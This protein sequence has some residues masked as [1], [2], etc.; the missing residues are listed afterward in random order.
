MLR[1]WSLQ[2]PVHV[3]ETDITRAI[4]LFCQAVTIQELLCH[5][6]APPKGQ[7][8]SKGEHFH[9]KAEQHLKES[10]TSVDMYMWERTIKP[11]KPMS[12][13]WTHLNTEDHN[14]MGKQRVS[15]KEIMAFH[16]QEDEGVKNIQTGQGLKK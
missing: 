12:L 15:R 14:E 13:V 7:W 2:K 6:P 9:C 3:K 11:Y 4:L 16:V 1:T 8:Q 5:P 10:Q